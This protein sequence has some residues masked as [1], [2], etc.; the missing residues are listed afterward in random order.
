M[1]AE[2]CTSPWWSAHLD[3]DVHVP[4]GEARAFS[5]T[6]YGAAG[7]WNNYVIVLR[8]ADLSEYGVFRSDNWG[9]GNAV[10]GMVLLVSLMQ[11]LRVNGQLGLLV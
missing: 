5:L 1:G 4:S 3:A 9:W 8:K 2:D 6:N 7:N 10:G 11:E